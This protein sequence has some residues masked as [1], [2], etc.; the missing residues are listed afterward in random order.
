LVSLSPPLPVAR[1]IAEA[2]LSVQIPNDR[3]LPNVLV[4]LHRQDVV[5]RT[6]VRPQDVSPA[7]VLNRQCQGDVAAGE[8]AY[9]SA[10]HQD[11]QSAEVAL[12]GPVA[13]LEQPSY[14]LQDAA[15]P[16]RLR[17]VDAVLK[18]RY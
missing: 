13:L 18:M 2:A 1:L 4:L 3:G 8:H 17:L 9:T 5:A 12:N 7:G 16:V 14:S 11:H 6:F 15:E 10:L